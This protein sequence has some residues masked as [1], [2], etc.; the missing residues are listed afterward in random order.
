MNLNVTD[1]AAPTKQIRDI[2]MAV[3]SAVS[4]SVSLKYLFKD[5]F[6]Y[7]SIPFISAKKV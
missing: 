4:V 1:T 7:I 2:V 3:R 5:L 6:F